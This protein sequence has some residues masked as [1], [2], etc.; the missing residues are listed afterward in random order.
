MKLNVK[1]NLFAGLLAILPLAVT[2]IIIQ[3]LFNLFSG[4]GKVFFGKFEILKS[5]FVEIT[6][7][8]FTMAI[9]F[10]LGLFVR[11]VL[12][13]K[14]LLW[15]EDVIGRIPLVKSIYKTT[16]QITTSIGIGNSRAFREVVFIEYPRKEI[17]TIAMVTG[18]SK[19]S[20]GTEYYQIFVP[21]T[22]NP[23][24]GFMLYIPKKDVIETKMSVEEGLSVII[25]GGMLA[26]EIND[27]K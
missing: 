4:P 15:F 5:P 3:F 1:Q 27:I 23:T 9:L 25:S 26:P 2:Y 16:K 20:E 13:K 24:S 17:W 10:F 22:P 12:G 19:D 8:V 21:T 14:L 18:R 6:G 11:Q 7:F